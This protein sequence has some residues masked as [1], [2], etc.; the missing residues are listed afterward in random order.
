MRRFHFIGLSIDQFPLTT[1][2]IQANREILSQTH[3][4][5][6]YDKDPTINFNK[7]FQI[8]SI[9]KEKQIKR[10]WSEKEKKLFQEGID[11]FGEKSKFIIFNFF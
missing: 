9:K 7:N 1:Q 6:I 10:K 2:I 4:D 8:K 5:S 3:I 11:K